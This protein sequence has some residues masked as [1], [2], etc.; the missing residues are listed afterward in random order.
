[1]NKDKLK[2]IGKYGLIFLAFLPQVLFAL[3]KPEWAIP[4][5]GLYQA[6][7]G[8]MPPGFVQATSASLGAVLLAKDKTS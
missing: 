7:T 6:A 8:G 1:M 2:L 4:L 5:Q 3:N